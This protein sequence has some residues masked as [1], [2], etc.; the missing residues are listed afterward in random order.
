[1]CRIPAPRLPRAFRP[2]LL[3]A[4]TASFVYAPGPLAACDICAVYTATELQESRTGLRLGLAQ[5]VSYFSTLQES[6][7]EIDN[8]NDEHMLSSISQFLIGYQAH[9]RVGLQL[10]VPLIVR[11][12]RR[13]VAGEAEPCW[14]EPLCGPTP[15][16]TVIE[17]DDETGFG[18]LSLLVDWLAYRYVDDA[19]VMRLA[20]HAG[21][22]VP[23]GESD[24]LAEELAP[25]TAQAPIRSL[26]N[27]GEDENGYQ[28]VHQGHTWAGPLSGIHGHDLA[29]GTGSLDAIFGANALLTHQRAFAS[30]RV[31]YVLRQE[32]DYT[33]EYADELTGGLSPGWFVLLDHRYSLALLG[34]L[35]VE[36]KGKDRLQG[37]RLADTAFTGLY[38]GPGFHFTW[39]SSL[40]VDFAA[41]IP[42]VRN[43]SDI[44]MVA[45]YRLRGGVMWRF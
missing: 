1:M 28:S 40:S 21:V 38:A 2:A 10:S 19:S 23:S 37:Q 27:A 24:R 3:F 9:P 45:D 42:A 41:D 4:L 22:K 14:L 16:S 6:G 12:F 20:L 29:L 13:A 43:N 34:S 30:A 8:L 7:D 31:Q 35:S 5:Q 26:G 18:D 11:D 36:S 44:Q 25:T 39:G 33:Y 17:D 32:G 15:P